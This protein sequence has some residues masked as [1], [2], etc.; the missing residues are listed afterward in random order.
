M[1]QTRTRPHPPFG[2]D[3]N[4]A[5]RP[6]WFCSAPEPTW[7]KD[8]RTLRLM[9]A[10]NGH[11]RVL[12]ILIGTGADVSAADEA[13]N[14]PADVAMETTRKRQMRKCE[15]LLMNSDIVKVL[16][17]AGADANTANANDVTAAYIEASGGHIGALEVPIGSEADAA[18]KGQHPPALIAACNSHGGALDVLV[19]AGA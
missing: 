9:T 16:I 19:G 10:S 2:R 4:V 5:L 11:R 13:E 18:N 7:G 1:R 15:L 3:S 17:R 6:C 12:E 8:Q 14:A